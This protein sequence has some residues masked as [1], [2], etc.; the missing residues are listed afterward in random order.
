ME[1]EKPNE[2]KWTYLRDRMER[3]YH[4][5][6]YL[7]LILGLLF[8]LLVAYHSD[9]WLVTMWRGLIFLATGGRS[10]PAG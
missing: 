2:R 8:V 1:T 4:R 3:V 9:D 6:E 10:D 7:F 5:A